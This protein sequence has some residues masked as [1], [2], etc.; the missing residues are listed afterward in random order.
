MATDYPPPANSYWKSNEPNGKIIL[1]G[2]S[3]NKISR[4]RGDVK[5]IKNLV[6]GL[7]IVMMV[8][9][10]V[11]LAD[12]TAK[13]HAAIVAAEKWLALVDAANYAAGWQTAAEY[14]KGAVSQEQLQQSLQAVRTPLGKTI[15]R[16]LT[17]KTYKT[18]LPGAPDGE[19]VVIQYQTAFQNKKSAIE[20][21]TPMLDK[22]GEWR[23]AGYYIK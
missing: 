3:A 11:A 15:S 1:L 13:E 18:A 19:Y 9:P 8:L 14:F 21:V 16:K 23:V 10:G 5:V 4:L 2:S 22:D 17:T 12:T 7:A 6:I 20:T